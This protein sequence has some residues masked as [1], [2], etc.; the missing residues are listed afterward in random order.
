MSVA[1]MSA[2]EVEIELYRDRCTVEEIVS[3]SGRTFLKGTWGGH[4]LV[5]VKAGVGKVNA[6]LCAQVLIDTFD[7]HTILC[8]GSAG[9]LNPSLDIGDIVVAEDCVQHDVLVEFLGLPRGQIPFT[10]HRFFETDP[11]LRRLATTVALPDRTVQ[12]G[13][14]LTGDTFVEDPS[15]RRRL[16]DELD[17]DCVEMEGAAVGQVCA[18]NDV[19]YLVVRAISDHAD[20]SS[21][22]DFQSFLQDAA[23]ASANVVLRLLEAR[24]ASCRNSA[25]DQERD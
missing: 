22:V 7:V 4:R 16:R 17:G 20:G 24:N 9:A 1:I 21:E 12:Q 23:Q 19:S 18:M 2:M 25:G 3:R 15:H 8:T 11:Q 10:E 6:A 5:F 13:R 14:V